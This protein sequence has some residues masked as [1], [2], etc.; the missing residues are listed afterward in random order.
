MSETKVLTTLFDAAYL[1]APEYR[2][3]VEAV[4]DSYDQ[5]TGILSE[6]VSQI[7]DAFG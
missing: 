4:L 5:P 3:H 7:V 2:E 6:F 1:N